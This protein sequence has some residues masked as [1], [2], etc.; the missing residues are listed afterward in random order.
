MIFDKDE[1]DNRLKI[2]YAEKVD[3]D[4]NKYTQKVIDELNNLDK[5]GGNNQKQLSLIY[6]KLTGKRI[7]VRKVDRINR[8]N[9][10]NRNRYQVQMKLTIE[11]EI[12]DEQGEVTKKI[13]E[14]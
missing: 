14:V 6:R 5:K 2:A 7:G 12:E 10:T 1:Y 3:Y 9:N 11:N 4:R 8:I 13:T